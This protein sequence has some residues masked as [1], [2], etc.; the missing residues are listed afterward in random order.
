MNRAGLIAARNRTVVLVG[1]S[2]S[3]G[4]L[5]V[6]ALAWSSIEL[7]LQR[8]PESKIVLLGVGRKPGQ[9]SFDSERSRQIVHTL[10]VRYS[11]NVC[12]T[13]HILRMT[14]A[15]MLFRCLPFT[16]KCWVK[17]DCALGALLRAHVICDITGGDS[18]SD[19][20][21]FQRYFKDYLL[22]RACQNMKRPYVL[23]PQ[24]YGP[25]K[26][27]LSRYM[28]KTVLKRTDLVLSRDAASLALI[29]ELTHS[30]QNDR[31]VLSP[32]VAFILESR[33]VNDS[34]TDWIRLINADGRTLIGVNVSGLLYHNGYTGR[35]EFALASDYKKLVLRLVTEFAAMKNVELLLV[36][37]VV[38]SGVNGDVESDLKASRDLLKSSEPSI[39]EHVRLTEGDY[40]QCEL[41]YLI[42]QCD[43]FIGSRMHSTIASLSQ[44][45][46]TVGLAYS[47]K[48]TGVYETIEMED[49]VL[50]LREL[51]EQEIVLQCLELYKLKDKLEQR[52]KISVPKAQDK[53]RALLNHVDL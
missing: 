48:F 45:T 5:G 10:P 41:K 9:V 50:D 16:A 24:T 7:I 31:C 4:N 52:L 3:T 36:P 8:W 13:N 29:R 23:L 32:D 22:K 26:H 38:P 17:E 49:C 21:G 28:A 40:D 6:S 1:A 39:R 19:I 51:T 25:F 33:M 34:L 27:F 47:R 11:L 20:Y 46:P 2:F 12:A 35:N 42:G 30:G 44:G 18:F 14:L 43:F 53:V 37:H 15:S